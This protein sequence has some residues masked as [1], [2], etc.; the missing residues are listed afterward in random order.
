[1]NKKYYFLLS[2]G[3]ILNVS[4]AQEQ[5]SLRDKANQLFS[6]YQYANAAS[7]YLKLA[8]VKKPR[9]IDLEHLAD[10]YQKMNDYESAENWYARVI[11]DPESKAENLVSY[12]AI[13]K[14]N[15]RYA[16]AKNILQQYSAK[17]G[18]VK[19]VANEI[20]GCD[21]AMIWMAKPTTHKIK[22]ES[23]VNTAF[24]EFSVFPFGNKVFYTGMPDDR[25]LKQ[26]DGRT[27]HSFLKI[28][29]ADRASDDALSAKLIDKAP[30]ND[31]EY[32]VGPIIS[33]QKGNTFFVTRTYTGKHAEISKENKQKFR[34][35]NLELFIYTVNDGKYEAR[36]FPY[37]DV[38]KYSVGHAALSRDEQTLYFVSDM[39]GG[40]GKTDIWYCE[41][42]KDGKWGIPQN[43][44][45]I[46]N[47]A[48]E[49]MFPNVAE[50]GT[51]YYSSNGLP[52][53]GGLDIFALKG[54][55]NNWSEP[56]NL[57]YPL[58][59]AGDDFAFITYDTK[60]D[61]NTGY[62][63]SDRKGGVG[64]DDIYSFSYSLPKI[65][66]AL[67]GITINKK[68]EALLPEAM[69]TLFDKN[70]RQIIG[71]QSTKNDGS[72]FFELEKEMDYTV[73]GQ[74]KTFY[75]DSATVSTKGLTKSDTLHV[76]LRLEPLF[77]I[78]KTIAIQNI[79]YNFDKDD[80]RPDAAKILEELV[81]TLRD[82]PELKI[83]LASYT[84]SR[85]AAI[86]NLALSQRRAG[87]VVNY[88]VRR[89]ISRSRLTA[90][91]YGETHLLNHCSD[92]VKCSASEHQA[93][94]RTEFKIISYSS[95]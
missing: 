33:N 28:F 8:D 55:K 87:S 93:N 81:R 90:K 84:D 69:V 43:A 64:S 51:L 63:S 25:F 57:R 30:Y 11:Q 22:N 7:I 74:K 20:A 78:G 13:L 35:N 40:L 18:D 50:D 44:G 42:Q 80:I 94:R 27:G 4:Y 62:L 70:G 17:T 2:L 10:C 21:S 65:I 1:M 85:G 54:A 12:G 32:H 92:G 9:L 14:S 56:V 91:G 59:S 15:S 3:C 29:T 89:G 36:P 73:L 61:A 58:N 24:A 52:G 72:F 83:E 95:E 49:E 5:P 77:E 68:T 19:R 26:K 60:D 41:L 75:S 16:E 67:T 48:E 53:M 46:V 76:S 66:L 23:A 45:S 34:T 38:K 88:L 47:T 86:Y 39:P 6:Q 31:Q 37:N 71:K 79:H 82:N